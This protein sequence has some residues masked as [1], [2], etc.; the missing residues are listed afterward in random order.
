[1]FNTNFKVQQKLHNK[2]AK[3]TLA[4]CKGV[5]QQ[6]TTHLNFSIFEQFK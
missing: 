1:M 6:V 2:F 5:I 4:T 3:L